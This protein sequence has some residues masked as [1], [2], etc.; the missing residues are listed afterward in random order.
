MILSRS[1]A[2]AAVDCESLPSPASGMLT[3]AT[4]RSELTSIVI[5]CLKCGLEAA[6]SR[7]SAIAA[8]TSGEV[9]SSALTAT[10][11]GIGP[12]GKTSCIAVVGLDHR[13]GPAAASDAGFAV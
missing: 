11:A 4:V 8:L 9:T 6:W 5:G 12:P 10:I 3:W 13:R 2:S 1:A 7:R